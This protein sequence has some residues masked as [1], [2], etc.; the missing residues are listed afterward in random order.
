MWPRTNCKQLN[1]ASAYFDG[2]LVEMKTVG[3]H[4]IA[5]TRNNVP[6]ELAGRSCGAEDFSNRSHKAVI[7]VS[8]IQLELYE[9]VLIGAGDHRLIQAGLRQQMLRIQRLTRDE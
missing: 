2:G 4:Y 9:N 7:K 6:R 5:S 1:G 3:E 8:G